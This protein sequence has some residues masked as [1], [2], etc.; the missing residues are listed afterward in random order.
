VILGAA[1]AAGAKVL[2]GVPG[3][4]PAQAPVPPVA[5]Q[6]PTTV[7]GRTVNELGDR[8]PFEHSRRRISNS[9]TSSQTP[10]DQL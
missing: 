10:L 1:T 6:D 5:V 3:A 2:Q 8:T 4:T 7:Q 9:G